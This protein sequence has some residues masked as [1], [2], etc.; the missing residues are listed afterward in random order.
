MRLLYSNLGTYTELN[1]WLINANLYTNL[2]TYTEFNY[3]LI[4][5]IFIY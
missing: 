1:H 2:G 5:A 3:W 4:S